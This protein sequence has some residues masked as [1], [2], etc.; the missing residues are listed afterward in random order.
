MKGTELV[1]YFEETKT[2]NKRTELSNLLQRQIVQLR[3][4]THNRQQLFQFNIYIC[5]LLVWA[6]T[7]KY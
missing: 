6:G 1:R 3:F 4:D 2:Q 5:W 7:L